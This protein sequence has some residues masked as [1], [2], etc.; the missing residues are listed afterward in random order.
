MSCR[1]EVTKQYLKDLKLAR[2]RM[3]DESMLND[4]IFKLANEQTL[5]AK[6]RD[7]PLIGNY[8]GCRECHITSDWLPIYRRDITLKIISLIRTGSHSDLF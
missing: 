2:K 8:K 5:P 3:L 4:I 1:I 7:H 6:N